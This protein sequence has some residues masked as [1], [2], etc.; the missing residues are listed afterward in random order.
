[1]EADYRRGYKDGYRDGY[2]EG[3]RDKEYLPVP[4]PT[5]SWRKGQPEPYN[6]QWT[7][8]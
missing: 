4:N 2:N 6:P 1:M 7:R 8:V 5:N 3:K